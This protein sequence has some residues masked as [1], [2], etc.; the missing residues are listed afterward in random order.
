MEVR[1]QFP[2]VTVIVSVY[3]KAAIVEKCIL[4]LLKIDYPHWENL[5][6]DGYSTDGSYE[7]LKIFAGAIKLV[8]IEGNYATAL[9]T[10]LKMVKTPLVAL[11]DADC[12]VDKDWL[13]ELVK[14]FDE[15]K[16]IVAVAGFVGT[17]EGLPLIATLTG[18]EYE[19][20]HVFFPHYLSRAPTMN[21][22]I[23]TDA[24]RRTGFDERLPIA[25]DT[26]F[27][28]RLSERGKIL[29]RPQAIVYHHPRLTWRGFFVQQVGFATGAALVYLRH[30]SKLRGDHISTFS[31]ILQ[32]PLFSLACLLLLLG[33]FMP[34]LLT[35]SLCMFLLLFGIY[36]W[37]IVRLPIRKRHYPPMCVLFLV[38]TLGWTVGAF[39]GLSRVLV[40]R[41][42]LRSGE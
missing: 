26:D 10:A 8:R 23:Q 13:R 2:A 17:P 1:N 19:R 29:Y 42:R 3:N 30:R 14:G 27:G 41:V 37:D 20:R 31:M 15:G 11:T 25:I 39:K 22:C 12:T 21:L 33:I 40:R 4:S 5:I 6:I 36:I 35:I 28:F 7:I 18:I 16:D 24:A 9:N 32:I 34:G 38:R